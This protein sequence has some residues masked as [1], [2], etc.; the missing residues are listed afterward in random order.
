MFFWSRKNVELPRGTEIS[1]SRSGYALY[2]VHRHVNISD[3]PK[4]QQNAWI[5]LSMGPQI[6]YRM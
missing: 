3:R 6:K 5:T 4:L 2:A 1:D